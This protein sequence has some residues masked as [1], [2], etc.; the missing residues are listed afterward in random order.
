MFSSKLP[1]LTKQRLQLKLLI[2]SGADIDQ[3][4]VGDKTRLLD[5]L[6]GEHDQQT[7]DKSAYIECLLQNGAKLG[8]STWLAARNKHQILL[9]LLRKL[10]QDGYFLYKVSNCCQLN[11]FAKT[12][13]LTFV[14]QSSSIEAAVYRFEYALK[15]LAELDQQVS[16]CSHF[17]R[18]QSFVQDQAT[19]SGS[20]RIRYQSYL[21]LSSCE[22]ERRVSIDDLFGTRQLREQHLTIVSVLQTRIGVCPS[23][24][25][26]R[27]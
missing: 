16:G 25:S 22:R 26:S 11:T 5:R 15:R 4:R 3:I 2:D 21:G 1:L 23:G 27:L 6:I 8:S 18:A 24:D 7:A 17:Q 9:R 10:C 12:R 20:R 14:S 13:L 19:L